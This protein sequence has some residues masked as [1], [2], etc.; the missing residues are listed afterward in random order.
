[1]RRKAHALKNGGTAKKATPR[2]KSRSNSVTKRNAAAASASTAA[3][4]HSALFTSQSTKGVEVQ[5][6]RLPSLPRQQSTP[7][8]FA[9]G[10]GSPPELMHS[11]SVPVGIG[12][13][14]AGG[15]VA[16]NG[17]GGGVAVPG[18]GD[19]PGSSPLYYKVNIKPVSIGDPGYA[20]AQ[21]ASTS[22]VKF[23]SRQ[24]AG[25]RRVHTS[26]NGSTLEKSASAAALGRTSRSALP[27]LTGS[28]ADMFSGIPGLTPDPLNVSDRSAPDLDS[29]S[30]SKGHQKRK[31]RHS[32]GNSLD[33]SFTSDM[34][35]PLHPVV[36]TGQAANDVH[37]SAALSGQ[38]PAPGFKPPKSRGK[39]KRRSKKRRGAG[40]DDEDMGYGKQDEDKSKLFEDV[41]LSAREKA[42]MQRAYLAGVNKGVASGGGVDRAQKVITGV[43]AD[44]DDLFLSSEAAGKMDKA[45]RGCCVLGVVRAY[46][47]A[48]VVVQGLQWSF[49]H[50]DSLDGL[51]LGLSMSLDPHDPALANTQHPSAAHPPIRAPGTGTMQGSA[52][53]SWGPLPNSLLEKDVGELSL[54]LSFTGMSLDESHR[55]R[56]S[57]LNLEVVG[58]SANIR[59]MDLTSSAGLM[60]PPPPG[61]M[62]SFLSPSEVPRSPGRGGG[63]GS[64][65]S[66]SKRES[67]A[68]GD[69]VS[70]TASQLSQL[71]QSFR[72]GQITAAQKGAMK[73][74][75]LGSHQGHVVSQQGGGG[76]G[77][78]GGDLLSPTAQQLHQVNQFFKGGHITRQQKDELKMS[79]LE[80][81][82][83][84]L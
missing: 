26:P 72:A 15:D 69:G 25:H 49:G 45:V 4:G 64:A 14:V 8:I 62:S 78:G 9:G 63:N 43:I 31:M 23:E 58:H 19:R 71:G 66:D 35:P 41:T 27:S 76:G 20:S 57:N 73:T 5:A 39:T 52:T 74:A 3:G 42:L 18:V 22:N 82:T 83:D 7:A 6:A 55:S 24:V 17:A 70:P 61:G 30:R 77:G 28:D 46:S 50:S 47:V 81:S 29:Y 36:L 38:S 65:A 53:G 48:H 59:P 40:P 56:G 32:L 68:T 51:G 79:I 33:N 10:V 44:H 37:G 1:M 34:G 54:S 13:G 12:G 16:M 75:I 84:S 11:S 80:A 60:E 2:R 67:K 21:Q